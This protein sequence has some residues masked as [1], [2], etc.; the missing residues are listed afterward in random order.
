VWCPYLLAGVHSRYDQLKQFID[1]SVEQGAKRIRVH[2]LTD[3]RD[4]PVSPAAQQRMEMLAAA[5]HGGGALPASQ[6]QLLVTTVKAVRLLSHALQPYTAGGFRSLVQCPGTVLRSGDNSRSMPQAI[7]AN[8]THSVGAWCHRTA[9]ASGL[10]T[11]WRRTSR[12]RAPPAATPRSRPAAAAWA[13]PWTAM[14]WGPAKC[15]RSSFP[16]LLQGLEKQSIRSP[17]RWGP[18]TAWSSGGMHVA[19]RALRAKLGNAGRQVR[20]HTPNIV[21]ADGRQQWQALSCLVWRMLRCQWAVQLRL[22]VPSLAP[23]RLTCGPQ[24]KCMSPAAYAP[25]RQTATS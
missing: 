15:S 12:R 20:P 1:G 16:S 5:R 3:G 4:V 24:Q 17:S 22:K 25:R 9:A 7:P 6:A 2:V 21:L 8:P 14:R 18:Q 19:S 11:S 23:P 10:S 13:S